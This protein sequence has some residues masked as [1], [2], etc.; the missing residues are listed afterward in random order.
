MEKKSCLKRLHMMLSL[1][2]EHKDEYAYEIH[3]FTP[4]NNFFVRY[5]YTRMEMCLWKHGCAV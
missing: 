4:A 1:N 3:V 2:K 5:N